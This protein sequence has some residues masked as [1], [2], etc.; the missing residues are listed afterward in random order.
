M[1]KPSLSATSNTHFQ[2]LVRNA[3]VGIVVLT[4][5]EMRIE[6]VNEYYARLL[7]TT[8]E[9][10]LHERLFDIIPEAADPFLPLLEK[11]RETGE[12]VYLYDQPRGM[13]VDGK[14]K[15]G[16]LNIIYQP[17]RQ[18]DG[19][20]TGV[21]ALCQDV[22]QQ[23]I[24]K[25]QL[26]DSEDR[27]RRLIEEA[28]IPMCL[29]TGREMKIQVINEALL[30]VWGKEKSVIGKTLYDALPELKGQGFL[31]LLQNVYDTRVPLVL[32]N[33]ES[34]VYREGEFH[35]LYFDLWYKPIVDEKS[36]NVQGILAS[37][38]DVS[39]KV[40]LQRKTEESESRFKLMV[41]HATVGIGLTKGLSMIF[42]N[43]NKPM[44]ELIDRT[45]VIGKP[46]FE[47]LPELKG[48]SI[49]KILNNVF[50]T[51]KS[52]TGNEIPVTLSLNGKPERR[53]YNLS[54][55]P[56]TENGA[57]THILHTTIDVTQQVLARQQVEEA[58]AKTNLA[59]ESADLGT[60]EI[61]LLTEEMSTSERFTAIWGADHS[62]MPRSD[63]VAFIHPE[64]RQLRTQAHEQALISGKL[65]YEAR[66]TWKDNSVHWVK[67]NGSVLYDKNHKPATL[68]GVIQDITEQKIIQ[69]RK[70]NFI[71]MASHELK[72]P[73]TS[74]KA[75]AQ[76]I[77]MMLAEKG[78]KEELQMIEKIDKQINS[79]TNLVS[80][81]LNI[82]K[83]DM[84]RLEYERTYFTLND[85]I[86]H[87]AEELQRTTTHQ[88]HI[89]L[90]TPVTVFADQNRIGQVISNY[91]TN[92]IKYSPDAGRINIKTKLTGNTVVVSVQD[93]GIGINS[94]EQR[95]VFDQF[96]RVNN[97][98]HQSFPGMGLGLYISATIIKNE[99]G[100]VWVESEEDK[101]STF[102]F[103]LPVAKP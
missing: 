18:V 91:I 56:F 27:F 57:V 46:L 87:V 38:V 20:I 86:M 68:I 52:Y 63:F 33:A 34:Q 32:K 95:L 12:P 8:P 101:G 74:V 65:Y 72:T 66:V 62:I 73:L 30:E 23:W 76:I 82:S 14:R 51:G 88:L 89:Q 58:N 19:T 1:E 71:A 42:E 47:V 49:E 36:G 5:R 3:S 43:I 29:Y 64:D 77:G 83:I 99:H 22:T 45:D 6:I 31:E 90:D 26:E 78:C 80:D 75:Y 85:C 9:D 79:L 7:D 55:V 81:L 92:A 39:E 70:D 84:G 13:Y 100:S 28:P 41:N 53:F 102:Y 4:G 60:Y 96:Y 37:G 11:V 93:Y 50:K 94:A 35:T 25:K 69:Q 98:K 44:L 67:V 59:I 21:I 16:Y 17:L 61:D 54:F 48:Q 40:L 103:C 15:E 10:L 2:D 97:A 24:H